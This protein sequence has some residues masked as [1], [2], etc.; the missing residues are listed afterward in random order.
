MNVAKGV[1]KGIDECQ[2]QFKYHRWNCSTFPNDL[3][4][5]GRGLVK[6]TSV[7][8]D[9]KIAQDCRAR[10]IIRPSWIWSAELNILNIGK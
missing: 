5:F 7:H 10:F 9:L 3:T 1:S 8:L 6:G 2:F 4:L